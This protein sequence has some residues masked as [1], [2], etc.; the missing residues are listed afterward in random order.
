MTRSRDTS[1]IGQN[2]KQKGKETFYVGAKLW[3]QPSANGAGATSHTNGAVAVDAIQFANGATKTSF[4]TYA[5]PKSYDGGML[6]YKLFYYGVSTTSG[7]LLKVMWKMES[8]NIRSDDDTINSN[9]GSIVT[10]DHTNNFQ[11]NGTTGSIDHSLT[12]L[13]SSGGVIGNHL[14]TTPFVNFQPNRTWAEGVTLCSFKLS[15]IG[16]GGSDT[17]SGAVN[18][19]GAQ[20]QYTTDLANDD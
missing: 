15:R 16:Q 13:Y 6:S 9:D 18:L 2:A 14:Q 12:A 5:L 1:K 4:A 11:T 19:I 7:Q 8:A 20:F 10:Q 17:Y 3:R